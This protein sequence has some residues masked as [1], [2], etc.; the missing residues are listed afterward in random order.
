MAVILRFNATL[1]NL[2]SN[3]N[4][5]LT[6]DGAAATATLAAK[7][8]TGTSIWIHFNCTTMLVLL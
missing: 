2:T 5:K 8:Y 7:D 6:I 3:V 1:Q 4:F